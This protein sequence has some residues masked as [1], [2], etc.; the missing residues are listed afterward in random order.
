MWKES[1]SVAVGVGVGIL[2]AKAIYNASKK[3]LDKSSTVELKNDVQMK[4]KDF[5]GLLQEQL[6][7]ENLS[8]DELAKWFRENAMLEAEDINKIVAYPTEEVLNGLGYEFAD[9]LDTKK[10]IIQT[11][12]NK[13]KEEILKLRF[14]S[15]A[16]IDSELKNVLQK[17]GM[18]VIE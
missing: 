11:F 10:S 5:S 16:E 7:I 2:I 9:E 6:V 4:L 1:I 3:Q 12:Y 14:I 13:E 15:F 8:G 18:L 17:D